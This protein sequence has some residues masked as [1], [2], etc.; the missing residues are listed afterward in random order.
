MTWNEEPCLSIW[1]K[2]TYPLELITMI[3]RGV[4]MQNDH[5]VQKVLP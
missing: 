1:R 3:V 5:G 4:L 2:Y